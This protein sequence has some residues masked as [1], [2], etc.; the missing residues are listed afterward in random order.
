MDINCQVIFMLPSP[1]TLPSG[2]EYEDIATA[3]LIKNNHIIICRNYKI[4]T[5]NFKGEIDIIS[6]K[7]GIIFLNEV[8]KRNTPEA[9]CITEKQQERIWYTYSFF[10]EENIDYNNS[11]VQMQLVLISGNSV[12]ILDI[13]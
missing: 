12:Q 10:L 3:F 2:M 11:A 8:K 6:K 1:K 5:K 7:N 9:A 4:S 13:L